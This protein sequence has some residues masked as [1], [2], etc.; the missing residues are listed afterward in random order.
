MRFPVIPSIFLLLLLVSAAVIVPNAVL[1]VPDKAELSRQ[2]SAQARLHVDLDGD[3]RL[4]F[5]PRPQLIISNVTARPIDDADQ[6]LSAAMMLVDIA[7]LALAQRQISVSGVSLIDVTANMRLADGVNG[8]MRQ[9]VGLSFPRLEFLNMQVRVSGLDRFDRR[10]ETV[11]SGLSVKLPARTGLDDFDISV[12]QARAE[13]AVRKFHMR[14]GDLTKRRQSVALRLQMAPNESLG[15]SGYIA[16]EAANWR[17]DGELSLNSD[18]VLSG[19][20]EN[21]LPIRF[22]ST[23][24]RVA[25]SGLVQADATGMQS[26]NLEITAL[27]SAFRARL[28]LAWPQQADARPQ[29]TGRLSTGVIDLDQISVTDA[30]D[31]TADMDIGALWRPFE[32]ALGVALRIEATRFDMGGESGQNLLLAF[33]WQEDRIDVQ[34]LSLGLPFRSLFLASGA[35]DLTNGTPRFDGSFSTRSTDALAAV[36]WLGELTAFDSAALV[37][38]LDENSLQR[39]SLVGDISV[40]E[41]ALSLMALSGRLGDDALSGNVQLALDEAA[42][43]RVE[44]YI[45]RFDLADWGDADATAQQAQTIDEALFQPVNAALG[46]WLSTADTQRNLNFEIAA[47]AFYSGVTD[48]GPVRLEGQIVD[49]S[50]IIRQMSL[51]AFRGLDMRFDGQ[52]NYDATPPHGVINMSM[53]GTQGLRPTMGGNLRG[54]LPLDLSQGRNVAANAVWRLSAPDDADWPNAELSGQGKFETID[55]DFS[56]SG[57]SRSVS[58]EAAGQKLDIGLTGEADDIADI[59]GLGLPYDAGAR[60]QLRFN[61]ESQNSNLAKMTAQL[62]AQNDRLSMVGTLRRAAAGRRLEG[63]LS[64]SL[65]NSLPLF[66]PQTT[67][68]AWPMQGEAQ[69]VSATDSLSFSGLT[70]TINN[71]RV[72]GEGVLERTGDTPKLTANLVAENIDFGWLL[73]QP[74]KAGWPQAPMK[75]APFAL[76]DVD[77]ELRGTQL[78]FGAVTLEEVATRLK[79]LGGVL[80]APQIT[81]R[82]LG[83]SFDADLVAEGGSLNP[84]FSLQASFDNLRSGAFLEQLYGVDLVDAPMTGNLD[85]SGRGTSVRAMMASLDGNLQLNLDSGFLRFVDMTGFAAAMQDE[86]FKGKAADLLGVSDASTPFERGIGLLRMRD[87]QAVNATLDFVF[88]DEAGWRDA[89]LMGQTDFVSRQVLG[90]MTLYPANDTKRLVWQLS[91]PLAKPLVKIDASDF[92]RVPQAAIEQAVTASPP[93]A[94]APSLE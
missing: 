41:D 22:S 51:P 3:V 79:L 84:Y 83:G 69:I 92:D 20:L 74:E 14:I 81:G 45:D 2:L 38:T 47:G 61:L 48:L 80:E 43:G 85:I 1:L 28:A 29:L 60:G 17:A 13:G 71:G 67:G 86:A 52:M 7:P 94:A 6:S 50:F 33:D 11:L 34:R 75:W 10:R 37:E 77:V 25:F 82:L 9:M 87:G 72:T 32:D 65:A 44:L 91:G 57:P 76:S 23:A 31:A 64:F 55:I 68:I 26:E 27:N 89:R 59:A 12:N 63:L 19:L 5:L 46:S 24:R 40:S 49:Q 88:D 18:T 66:S 93:S 15:F 36:L 78:A 35:M 8:L 30:P 39:I 21:R 56:L 58:I 62:S 42:R 16:G 73:P 90:D 54:L 4:R 53:R 70:A